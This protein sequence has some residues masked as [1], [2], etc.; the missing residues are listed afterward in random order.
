M[1]QQTEQELYQARREKSAL[2][3]VWSNNFL[4][5]LELILEKCFLKPKSKKEHFITKEKLEVEIIKLLQTQKKFLNKD[6]FRS[7]LSTQAAFDKIDNAVAKILS[8]ELSTRTVKILT[9]HGKTLTRSF[10]DVTF[11]DVYSLQFLAI[12]E[13]QKIIYNFTYRETFRFLTHIDKEKQA[14]PVSHFCFQSREKLVIPIDY[15]KF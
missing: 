14:E 15:G 12:F 10:D 4:N 8:L 6:N 11:F 2:K 7:S 13:Q 5:E 3:K 9:I 1:L